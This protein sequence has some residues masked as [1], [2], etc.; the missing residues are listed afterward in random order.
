VMAASAMNYLYDKGLIRTGLI[1][2]P[3][4][5]ALSTWPYELSKWKHLERLP[6]SVLV[7][8]DAISRS[9][10]LAKPFIVANFELIGWLAA[11]DP[12]RRDCV[13][14]DEVTKFKSHRSKR[15][16]VFVDAMRR[17]AKRAW[18]L[19]A[20][21]VTEDDLPALWGQ[22]NA[23]D[24]GKRLGGW[25]D[26]SDRYLIVNKYDHTVRPRPGAFGDITDKLKD[27]T[28][29][30]PDE[31]VEYQRPELVT[32]TLW[33]DLPP[34]PRH[35]HDAV[36]DTLISEIK[37]GVVHNRGVASHLCHQITGGACYAV[38]GTEVID[39][40][41]EKLKLLEEVIGGHAPNTGIL[42]AYWYRHELSRLRQFFNGM[43]EAREPGAIDLWNQK[44]IRTLA[45]HPASAGHG[46]DLQ[47]GGNVLVFYSLPWSHGLTD[48]TIGR[49]WRQGQARACFVH[50]LAARDTVDEALMHAWERKI[51]TEQAILETFD[52]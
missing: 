1:L 49:I 2:A 23:I 41:D 10:R 13:I 3:Y 16:R 47:P 4:Q 30:I 20:S 43:V 24:G 39:L 14:I 11:H 15:L 19:T 7:G 31:V 26:F 52:A 34:G 5:V 38:D 36:L 48:Q 46:L 44:K 18:G 9:A 8:E 35:E 12:I 50:F 27:A 33:C 42:I 37:R 21:P 17:N 40:H 32:Q 6:F 22:W 45:I 29:R 28:R 25:S 51:D